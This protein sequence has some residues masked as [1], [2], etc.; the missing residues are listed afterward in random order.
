MG[1]VQVLKGIINSTSLIVPFGAQFPW[2]GSWKIKEYG[3]K[4]F[5][6]KFPS[7]ARLR[8]IIEYPQLGLRG[9]NVIVKVSKWS[10][11]SAAKFKLFSVWVRIFG[12]PE[13]LL[14]KD[15]FEE[16]AYFLGIVQ[17]EDR[18]GYR[19]I[20]IVRAKVGVKDPRKIPEVA[21]LVVDP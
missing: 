8:E 7:I 5:L 13:S 19:D 11:A 1:L 12:I 6:A 2:G 20:D 14:H 9:T 18:Q 17:D 10:S 21:E 16:I 4:A 3:E 15:G